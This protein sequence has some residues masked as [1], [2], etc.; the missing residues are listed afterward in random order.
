M[1]AQSC[2]LII[3]SSIILYVS[4]ISMKCPLWYMNRWNATG[5]KY[6]SG[7]ENY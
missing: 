6:H 3:I 4:V 5:I 2:E 7:K 1:K